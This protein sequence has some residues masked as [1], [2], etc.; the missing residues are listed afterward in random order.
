MAADNKPRPQLVESH[1]PRGGPR[2]R[3]F[4]IDVN[5]IVHVSAKDMGTGK[6]QQIT[7]TASTNFLMQKL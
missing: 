2:L 3:L 7:I 4:D 6:E 1:I 5:G